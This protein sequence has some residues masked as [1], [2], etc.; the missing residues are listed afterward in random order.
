MYLRILLKMC[1]ILHNKLLTL[2]YEYAI[3]LKWIGA[4]E[5]YHLFSIISRILS[6]RA[7]TRGNFSH[8]R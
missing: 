2:Y 1:N 8:A 4:S 7:F 6:L 3:S 5:K